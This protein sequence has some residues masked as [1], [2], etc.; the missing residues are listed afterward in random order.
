MKFNIS[1]YSTALFATWYFVEEL[2]LLFDAG[3][4]VAASLLQKARK[5]EHVF[6]SHADRDHLGG[7]LQ[8][9]QLNARDGY[10]I[11]HY[12]AHCG[13]FPAIEEFTKKFDPHVKGT[14]WKPVI[15]DEEIQIADHLIV[16][17]IRNE[18]VKADKGIHKSFSYKVYQTKIKL[19]SEYASLPQDKIKQL[20]S[21]S[22]REALSEIVRTNIITYSGDT[23]VDDYAKWD[24]SKILIHE[25]TFLGGKDEERINKHGNK[26]SNLDEVIKMVSEINI[27]T[28]ILG[29]FSSRYSNEQ[30]DEQIKK[31]CKEYSIKIPVYRV[32]PGQI[33]RDILKGEPIN[34]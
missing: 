8:F 7:L 23:P 33:H 27:E 2:G 14:V 1:G 19:K 11:L 30:I 21:E 17:A 29:H 31:L 6:I 32:F 4:G 9:N 26:H 22:G 16:K 13:S 18:H 24:N 34:Q 15:E 12:P 28:L 5:V 3:D 20:I 25:A 10:P